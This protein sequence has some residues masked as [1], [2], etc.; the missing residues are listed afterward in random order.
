MTTLRRTFHV[1]DIENCCA[2]PFPSATQMTAMFREYERITELGPCD[3]GIAAVHRD[4]LPELLFD[5]PRWLRWILAPNGKDAADNALL[6]V[7]D[8]RLILQRYDRLVI[9]SADH[10]FTGLAERMAAAG[11]HVV[12]AYSAKSRI[13]SGLYRST[14]DTRCFGSNDDE[15]SV[16]SSARCLEPSAA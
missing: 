6:A 1:L 3:H 12:V 4:A 8:E 5:L 9:A 7:V 10:A 15:C 2:D 14:R 13:S 16:E 11:V